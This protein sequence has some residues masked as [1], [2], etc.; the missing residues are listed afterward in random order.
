M[1]SITDQPLKTDANPSFAQRPLVICRSKIAWL[2][3]A[4][5]WVAMESPVIRNL[6]EAQQ[7]RHH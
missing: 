6:M 4:E 3:A 7:R 5:Q 1:E 2:K